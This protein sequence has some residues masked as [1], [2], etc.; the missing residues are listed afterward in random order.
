MLTYEKQIII[1]SA[2]KALLYEVSCFPK[3]G[4]VDPID[5]GSHQDMDLYTFIDSSVVLNS[6]FERFLI[7]GEETKMEEPTIVFMKSRALGIAAENEMLTATHQINTHKGAIFTLGIFLI[8]CGRLEIW[9]NTVSLIQ[10]Q[11]VIRQLTKKLSEDFDNLHR[12]ETKSLTWGEKLYLET[13]SLGIRGEA[14]DGYPG[15]INKGLPFY[16]QHTGTKQVKLLDTLLF[17]LLTIEDTNLLKRSK[18]MAIYSEIQPL[19]T[20]YF[21]LGGVGTSEGKIYLDLLNR[22]F[23]KNNWSIGGSADALILTIFLDL[24]IERNYITM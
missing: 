18:N 11:T 23:K 13:G 14:M 17:L 4:L 8:A 5:P 3:P 9:Q 15:I 24:L 16:H 6:F 7:L 1:Q 19:I 22:L 20:R 12:K 10:L 2:Q 21:D